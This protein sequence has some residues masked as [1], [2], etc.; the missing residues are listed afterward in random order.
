MGCGDCAGDDG[1]HRRVEPRRR[2]GWCWRDHERAAGASEGCLSAAV[3]RRDRGSGH[4]RA[5]GR[6][7]RPLHA[8][9]LHAERP[10]VSG[11]HGD[12]P[13][14][15]QRTRPGASS[16]RHRRRPRRDR[17]AHR[18]GVRRAG[19]VT[20]QRPGERA[21]DAAGPARVGC[22][23]REPVGRLGA[24]RH[25][26]A[27]WSGRDRGAGGDAAAH[28]AVEIRRDGAAAGVCTRQPSA[29]SSCD[30]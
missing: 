11:R 27:F 10:P 25:R 3:E 21:A 24:L 1:A 7:H 17:G 23:H 15:G 2:R 22:A 12:R 26:A 5:G 9:R 28:R 6:S 29:A 20:W 4:R 8:G 16:R 18:F 14:L 19:S 13:G 30:D